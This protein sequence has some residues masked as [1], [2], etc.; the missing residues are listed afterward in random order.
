MRDHQAIVVLR[1]QRPQRACAAAEGSRAATS[2]SSR[3]E[4][5]AAPL[6]GLR[7]Q[8]K[9]CLRNSFALLALNVGAQL[10]RAPL[11]STAMHFQDDPSRGKSATTRPYSRPKIKDPGSDP[12]IAMARDRRKKELAI[13]EQALIV[14]GLTGNVMHKELRLADLEKEIKAIKDGVDE[15]QAQVDLL[16]DAQKDHRKT[17]AKHEEWCATFERLIGPFEAKYEES[18]A[19]VAKSYEFAKGKYHESLQKLVDDFGFHPAF[20]RWFDEF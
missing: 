17:I 6:H 19:E 7:Q 13:E 15:Y 5:S 14:S 11:D 3:H 2:C 12:V 10:A 8:L 16:R 1:L 18:K 20:K 4:L 9:A